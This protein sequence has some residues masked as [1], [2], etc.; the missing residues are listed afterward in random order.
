M[1]IASAGCRLFFGRTAL[2]SHRPRMELHGS[3]SPEGWFFLMACEM[4]VLGKRDFRLPGLGSF[5]Q[6]AASAGD[7]SAIIA[8][9]VAMIAVIVLLDQLV[10]RPAIAWSDK[11]KFEQVES[12]AAPTSGVLN[13][14][15]RSPL[16][17]R[18][19]HAVLS[20]MTERIYSRSAQRHAPEAPCS[21]GIPLAGDSRTGNRRRPG[22]SPDRLRRLG[23]LLHPP[24][25][26]FGRNRKQP[27][28]A[29]SF[30]F[31]RVVASL[32]IAAV[33]TIP[34]GVAIGFHPRLARIA[35]P[36][37]QIAASRPRPR[38]Y[39]RSSCSA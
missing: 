8:G 32:V 1:S 5:L 4:F 31:L 18:L 35:Q 16:L 22:N 39:S 19:Q 17:S 13:L 24:H 14:L 2:W 28:R 20:P 3:P 10:W 38:H 7:T 26:H 11:F 25:H 29:R 21:R 27:S 30:T 36:L 34:V 6:S 15:R 12:S 37:A 9:L 23:S 33:W